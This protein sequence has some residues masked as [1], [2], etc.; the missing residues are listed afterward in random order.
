MYQFQ[1]YSIDINKYDNTVFLV[2]FSGTHSQ[3]TGWDSAVQMPLE[4]D[5]KK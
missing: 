5:I 1:F 2:N 4:Q 3:F